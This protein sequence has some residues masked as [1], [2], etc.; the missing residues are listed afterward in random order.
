MCEKCLEDSVIRKKG[1]TRV[2][3]AGSDYCTG[4]L[5]IF[6]RPHILTSSRIESAYILF[7]D[8]L[9]NKWNDGAALFGK[10]NN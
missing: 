3:R 5:E 9:D 4:A 1:W 2:C 8:F 6:K 10:R 7:E